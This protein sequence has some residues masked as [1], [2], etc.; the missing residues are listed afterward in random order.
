MI[1]T[2]DGKKLLLLRLLAHGI[3]R[4]QIARAIDEQ[5]HKF[6]F[7]QVYEINGKKLLQTSL[8]VNITVLFDSLKK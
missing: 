4:F 8:K 3:F 6:H 2:R 5:F 1:T 7:I